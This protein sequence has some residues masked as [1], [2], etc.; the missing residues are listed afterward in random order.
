MEVIMDLKK[1][2]LCLLVLS[3]SIF[4][5]TSATTTTNIAPIATD[6]V[7][8]IPAD[9]TIVL[10]GIRTVAI[11]PFA[12]YSHQQNHL[13]TEAWG[14]N[15][16]ILEAV[17]DQ[18]TAHGITVAV[19]EDVNTLLVDENII[20]PID[21]DKYLIQGTKENE[22]EQ[23]KKI[24]TP[25]YEVVNVEHS[26][27]M[28]KEVLKII[29]FTERKKPAAS[30]TSPVLQGATVGLS[31][32]KIIELGDKLGVDIIVRGRIID[33]GYK[34]IGTI[35]PLYRG[36]IPIVIDSVKDIMYGATNAYGYEGDLQN[37]E[38]MAAGGA[39]GY[40]IGEKV[41]DA[42]HGAA[43]LAIGTASG[44]MASQHPKKAKRA[45]VVQVRV[46]AQNALNGE[47]LWTNRTEIEYTPK[48]NFAYNETHPKTMFDNAV[49]SGIKQLMDD[50]FKEAT[51]IDTKAAAP[52]KPAEPVV[53]AKPGV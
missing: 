12:D 4:G 35:N 28:T 38:N 2:F 45:A 8:Y 42:T 36:V 46:Y 7:K 10:A 21:K 31:K 39:M 32:D 52:D 50:F 37:V 18:F 53:E 47:V 41:Q 3:I 26:P 24:S 23:G 44:W 40:A 33:Y 20:R 6:N 51:N 34:D 14:G 11:F 15:I 29:D 43:G 16:K 13:E 19:Q 22:D 30:S 49:K 9:N 17:T 27:D 25:E 48:S 1:F 5:C